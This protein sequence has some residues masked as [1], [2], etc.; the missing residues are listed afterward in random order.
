MI[1]KAMVCLPLKML[2]AIMKIIKRHIYI[3]EGE[4]SSSMIRIVHRLGC[5]DLMYGLQ[6]V[7]WG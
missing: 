4:E 1:K 7:V 2:K 3:L 6:G 5:A